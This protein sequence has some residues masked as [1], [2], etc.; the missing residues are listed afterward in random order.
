MSAAWRITRV[1]GGQGGFDNER[2]KTEYPHPNPL[3]SIFQDSLN[4]RGEHVRFD[5]GGGDKF[6]KGRT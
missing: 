4:G 3:R 1:R 6:V 2:M 5:Q